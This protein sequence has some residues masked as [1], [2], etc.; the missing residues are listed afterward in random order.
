MIF[1]SQKWLAMGS[2]WI[3]GKTHFS[4]TFDPFFVAKRTIF[5][6]FCDFGGVKFASNGLKVGSFH[7]L[8][9]IK[10][11]RIIFGKTHF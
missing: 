6:A 1:E 9:Y 8:G 2:K 10:W 7:L 11:S 3:F 4:S 5:K